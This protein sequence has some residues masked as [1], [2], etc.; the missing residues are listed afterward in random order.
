MFK[1]HHAEREITDAQSGVL[2]WWGVC[3][4]SRP[5]LCDHMD[6]SP[7]G[8]SVHGILQVR[9]LEWVAF[10]FS[11]GS[12]WP[13]DQTHASCTGRQVLYYWDMSEAHYWNTV[14]KNS[15]KETAELEK[16]NYVCFG[17]LWA[18][19]SL[20]LILKSD[21]IS[22]I[23]LFMVFQLISQILNPVFQVR[24]KS[25]DYLELLFESIKLTK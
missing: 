25:V 2:L 15:S 19:L 11:G 8:S 7:P 9:I 23:C 1:E 5:T 16:Q 4:H 24:D 20:L 3:A 17:K 14:C 13:G 18:I 22:F 21:S 10:S 12:S 6:C